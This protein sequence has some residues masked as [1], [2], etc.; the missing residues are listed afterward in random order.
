MR[1]IALVPILG[2]VALG[3]LVDT[4]FPSA[5]GTRGRFLLLPIHLSYI[6]FSSHTTLF[7]LLLFFLSLLSFYALGISYYGV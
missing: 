2:W 4:A 5:A 3:F 7:S 6:A 1:Y